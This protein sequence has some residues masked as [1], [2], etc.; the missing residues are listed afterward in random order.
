MKGQ[1][2]TL[3]TVRHLAL[4]LLKF[5][6]RIGTKGIN[7]LRDSAAGDA[8]KSLRMFVFSCVGSDG[9]LP[10]VRRP[11]P[12]GRGEEEGGG[13]ERPRRKW[14]LTGGNVV[15]DDRRQRGGGVATSALKQVRFRTRIFT[16]CCPRE[17]FTKRVASS[18][19][20]T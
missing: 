10:P 6:A 5:F 16:C 20:E 13:E 18:T 4:E 17:R 12:L 8:A 9:F 2:E 15:E 1:A 7:P 14:L 11:S 3:L 19:L